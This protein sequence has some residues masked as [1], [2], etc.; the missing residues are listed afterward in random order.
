MAKEPKKWN[1]KKLKSRPSKAYSALL[2]IVSEAITSRIVYLKSII[3]VCEGPNKI[4][5][6]LD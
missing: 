3:D 2:Y 4:Y 6:N 5:V 1:H